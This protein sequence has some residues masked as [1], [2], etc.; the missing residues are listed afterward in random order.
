VLIP[1]LVTSAVVGAWP[2]LLTFLIAGGTTFSFFGPTPAGATQTQVVVNVVISLLNVSAAILLGGMVYRARLRSAAMLNEL[3]AEATRREAAEKERRETEE[4]RRQS[5]KMEAIGQ[6]AGGLAHDFNNQLSG[7]SGFARF[8]ARD[9]NLSPA[10]REDIKLVLQA[11]DRMAVL[12]R[13]LLAFSRRQVLTPETVSLNNV[14]LESQPLIQRLLGPTIQVQCETDGAPVWVRVDRAQL[15]QVLLN[16]AINARDAMPDGGTVRLKVNVR[17]VT[18]PIPML[19]AP[20]VGS[21]EEVA[22]GSYAQLI[23]E[24][25]GV[26]IPPEH[27]PRIFEPFFTTKEVGQGTGLGLSTVIGVVAQSQGYVWAESQ[28]GTGSRFT[29]LFPLVDAPADGEPTPV[30]SGDHPKASP[31]NGDRHR[32][33]VV[34]D[35]PTVR[36]L[37][38]RILEEAGYQVLQAQN[39]Q[40]ALDLIGGQQGRIRLVV[41]DVMMPVLGG[42]EFAERLSS[43]HPGLPVIW[44]S[45]YGQEIVNGGNGGSPDGFDPGF[46][47]LQKPV[48]PATLL[49]EVQEALRPATA[50]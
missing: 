10:S 15:T 34:D 48:A 31:D 39:G 24:D 47:F 23:V 16:L 11:A 33:L 9:P 3:R 35:E 45:G 6:L 41:S 26:G 25:S 49:A 20:I 19:R 8:V 21:S 7:L 42:R 37:M 2:G 50:S 22:R 4:L 32:I 40:E 28:P 14:I 12:T 13:Q 17:E 27:M 38:S 43:G 44:M 5:A 1:V 30:I 46:I 18:E 36:K 29:I